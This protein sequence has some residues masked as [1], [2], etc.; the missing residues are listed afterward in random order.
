M[1]LMVS[2]VIAL[3]L[4]PPGIVVVFLLIAVI[5]WGRYWARILTVFSLLLLW[6]LSTE[7]VRDMLTQ[8]LEF[9]YSVFN[10]A[11][12]PQ[13]HSAIVLLGGGLYEAAPEYAGEDMLNNDA[14][15]RTVYAA[16][17][18]RKT[19]LDVY[20][21]GGIPLNQANR[22]EGEVM[23]DW[24]IRWGL[25]E[26]KVFAESASDN[27]WQNAIYTRAILEEKGIKVILWVT[28]AWHM[29]RAVW[30]FEAQ[31]LKVISAPTGFLTKQKAYDL[32]SYMPSGHVL[33]NSTDALHEYL[34]MLWYR[35]RY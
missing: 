1:M 24:L 11:D 26:S 22:A 30:C 6:A 25:P 29:P 33:A 3:W 18:A 28:S 23:R 9:Q 8:P 31:G 27:T 15:M 13:E 19:G 35:L 17:I 20:A 12:V 4:L 10:L 7:P 16:D 14:L 5:Y 32:R 34:G 2:K 21:T